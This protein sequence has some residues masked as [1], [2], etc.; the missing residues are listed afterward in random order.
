MIKGVVFDLDGTLVDSVGIWCEMWSKALKNVGINVNPESIKP[1]IGTDLKSILKNLGYQHA[2][3]EKIRA[4]REKISKSYAEK[5]K[6][7]PETKQVLQLIRSKGLK[8]AIAS[9]SRIE[10]IDYISKKEGFAELIDAYASGEEVSMQKPNPEIFE[11]AFKKLNIIP[12]E[13][14][15]VGDRETDTIPALSIGAFSILVDRESYYKEPRADL[16]I[17][18]LEEVPKIIDELNSRRGMAQF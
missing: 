12:K 18:S 7:F 4:E 10:W 6:A 11:L 13:G 2:D 5:V 15:V 16:F 17:K 14:V 3:I 1:F 8:I 9:T